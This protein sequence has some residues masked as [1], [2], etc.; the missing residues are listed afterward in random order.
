MTT[1]ITTP[2]TAIA[3]TT[4]ASLGSPTPAP[5]RPDR[6]RWVR[7]VG[8][9]HLVALAAVA[10]AIFPLLFVV[11]ASLNPIGTVASTSIIPRQISFE[12]F[13]RL[14]S[15]ERGPFLRWYLNTLILCTLVSAAQVLCS[16][17]AAYAFSRFRFRG[18]RTGLLALLLIQM[19]PQFLA[20]IALFS[21]FAGIGEIVPALGLNSILGYGLVLMGGAL[22][23]V[24]LIKGFF[25]TVPR[26]LDEAAM[27]DG[28]SHAQAFF[29][30]IL[31]LVTPILAT[32]GLLAF[33]GVANEF[34]IASIFLTDAESKTLATGLY[35]II[36]GDRSNNLG[37]FAA[38]SVLFS[39]P[40]IIL[41]QYLQRFIT[42]GLTAGAVKG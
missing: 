25:D 26:D 14:L 40:V 10:F 20:V 30:I 1:P 37:L 13:T 28:A 33:I 17:L 6:A 24:W 16:A 29:R 11:S 42:G 9:R 41:F 38:G 35:G 5:R 32:T 31:P 8:W 34:I 3:G 7:E 18:R 36:D 4:A 12:N 15:G 2:G 19:F 27:L 22:L 23:Q 39:I 21:M